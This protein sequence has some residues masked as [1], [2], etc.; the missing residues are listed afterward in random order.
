MQSIDKYFHLHN[1]PD[2]S[3]DASLG[4]FSWGSWDPA[5]ALN[6]KE[7]FRK[8][9]KYLLLIKELRNHYIAKCIELSKKHKMSLKELFRAEQWQI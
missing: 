9:R 8:L 5:R 3:R 2:S 7:R 1:F 4:C 6:G